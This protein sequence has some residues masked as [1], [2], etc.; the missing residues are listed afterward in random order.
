MWRWVRRIL[1][2][3]AVAA[4][5]GAAGCSLSEAGTPVKAPGG[6]PPGSVDINLLGTGNLPTQPAPPLGAAGSPTQGALIDAR[7]MANSVV[8]PWEV[9][10]ALVTPSPLRAMVL[11]DAAAVGL[12]EPAAVAAAAQAHNFINGFASDRLG[13]NQDLNQERLM[14]AVLRFADPPS[15][16]AAAADMAAKSSAIQQTKPM[17]IPGHPDALASSYSFYGDDQHTLIAMSYTPHGAYVLCQKVQTTRDAAVG[18]IARTLDLQTPLIDQFSPTDPSQFSN[19]PADPTG[20]LAHTMPAPTWPETPNPSELTAP[21]NPKVGI[22]QPHAALHLSDD[23]PSTDAAMSTAGVQAVSY[24]QTVVY[25]A[26][27]PAAATQL[28]ADL[29][30]AALKLEPSAES[31]EG[32]DFLPSSRCLRS[33]RANG[34][35]QFEYYCYAAAENFTIEA[36]GADATGTHQLLAA[37]YKML[38]AH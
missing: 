10:P 20:L 25:Q 1:P 16:A 33:D 31:S 18:L 14:N 15:A 27:D 38:L 37:Q 21:A 36:H 30:D 28:A 4:L 3:L 7:R 2:A 9:D 5:A 29:A 19:L 35:S 26:R 32:V 17:P 23:P 24:N 34:S 22:Y 13:L 12:I 11:K 6:P 8:G